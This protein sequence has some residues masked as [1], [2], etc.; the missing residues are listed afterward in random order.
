MI[1]AIEII[2]SELRRAN[3]LK[4]EASQSKKE[5]CEE[6]VVIYMSVSFEMTVLAIDSCKRHEQIQSTDFYYELLDLIQNC[7]VE[8]T[9]QT[10]KLLFRKN[11][12]F[13]LL[14]N[15]AEQVL[16]KYKLKEVNQGEENDVPK[17]PCSQLLKELIALDYQLLYMLN[18]V[19]SSF[20]KETFPTKS[21][22][23][24]KLWGMIKDIFKVIF[25][26]QT[27]SKFLNEIEVR[28]WTSFDLIEL[29]K[30]MN[31]I[32][33]WVMSRLAFKGEYVS[34]VKHWNSYVESLI[35]V[36]IRTDNDVIKLIELC[37][38]VFDT[39]NYNLGTSILKGILA[40]DL[41]EKYIF[42]NESSRVKLFCQKMEIWDGFENINWRGMEEVIK[43]DDRNKIIYPLDSLFDKSGE[44]VDQKP[45]EAS[46]QNAK[47][48]VEE[49]SHFDHA[50]MEHWILSQKVPL[51]H[52]KR[53]KLKAMINVPSPFLKDIEPNIDTY[54]FDLLSRGLI[55]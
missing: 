36:L 17:K 5:R 11:E 18:D 19:Y 38:F 1:E 2:S 33:Y 31:L 35:Y 6:L 48:L 43:E 55:Q 41:A 28:E 49:R 4:Q 40:S 37:N 25:Q 20:F 44:I 52:G 46:S 14:K 24:L 8:A 53:I 47:A 32:D 13:S 39:Q 30:T 7:I 26:R 22:D 12:K 29:S 42:E 34:K 51:M 9:E 16:K 15:N 50:I 3:E 21:D 27:T 54:S 45:L 23:F 10:D